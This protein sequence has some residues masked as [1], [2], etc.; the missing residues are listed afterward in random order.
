MLPSVFSAL[1]KAIAGDFRKAIAPVLAVADLESAEGRERATPEIT[2]VVRRFRDSATELG[3]RLLTESAPRGVTPYLP[4]PEPYPVEAVED[5]IRQTRSPA[6]L[7]NRLTRHAVMPAR[8]QVERATR[9][10]AREYISP[11][12]DL[13]KEWKATGRNEEFTQYAADKKVH[14]V[15]WARLLTGAE[16]C[17]FCLMLAS[18]GAVYTSLSHALRA[19]NSDVA[20][21]SGALGA[22][23]DSCD[24]I[25]VPVYDLSAGYPGQAQA[26][27]LST[28]WEQATNG[29]KA[30][31]RKFS[32]NDS[33]RAFA[34]YMKENPDWAEDVPAMDATEQDELK[35]I[36]RDRINAK[37]DS[38]QGMPKPSVYADLPGAREVWEES[39]AEALRRI[40]RRAQ[41]EKQHQTGTIDPQQIFKK[42]MQ[43]TLEAYVEQ[44][45]GGTHE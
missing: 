42:R 5:T 12:S 15:A 33:L 20:S 2:K 44:L 25:A 43:E 16:N 24:C 27:H 40:E 35:D 39:K 26:E 17:P 32:E 23:H 36:A 9:P 37:S 28:L 34:E 29:T 4:E 14:P 45:K 38:Y 31:G 8:R 7:L 13:R 41:G 11:I 30:F 6:E 22:Y 1:F 10:P 3:N 21:A 18:R 19:K